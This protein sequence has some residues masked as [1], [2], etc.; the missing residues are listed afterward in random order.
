[1]RD[2][3]QKYGKKS[4]TIMAQKKSRPTESELKPTAITYVP[5]KKLMSLIGGQIEKTHS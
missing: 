5:Y 2:K 1:M 4:K 3:N